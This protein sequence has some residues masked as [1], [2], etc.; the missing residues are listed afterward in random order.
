MIGSMVF[1]ADMADMM[2]VW[3]L[4]VAQWIGPFIIMVLGCLS[5]KFLMNRQWSQFINML[6]IGIGVAVVVYVAPDMFGQDSALTQSVGE[7]AKQIN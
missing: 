6:S 2:A 5:L 3:N 1:A 4:V 7:T